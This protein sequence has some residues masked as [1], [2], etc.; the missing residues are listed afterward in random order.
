MSDWEKANAALNAIDNAIR[1]KWEERLAWA[2]VNTTGWE[3][4]QLQERRAAIEFHI[5][6]LARRNGVVRFPRSEPP[7][8]VA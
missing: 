6:E 5:H 8:I 3:L 4:R 7:M 2:Y 1:R